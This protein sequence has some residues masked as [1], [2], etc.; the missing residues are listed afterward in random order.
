MQPTILTAVFVL[1]FGPGRPVTVPTPKPL[2]Y[3]AFSLDDRYGNTFVNTVFKDNILLA[4]RYTTGGAVNPNTLNWTAIQKPFTASLT[5]RPGET[6]AFHDNVLPE[7]R[8]KI[9]KTPGVH[10]TSAEGFKSDGYLVGDGVCHLASLL[11]WVARD[12]G[13]AAYAPVRHNFAPIADVPK[14]YGVSIYALGD[15]RG[16]ELQNLYITNTKP[17]PVVFRFSFDGT[18]LGITAI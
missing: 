5:L 6:F 3:H 13:L 1:L 4:V 10:F 8:G 11:Y 15:S 17:E 18:K 7:Y 12:A 16:S 2:A 9:A 14:E